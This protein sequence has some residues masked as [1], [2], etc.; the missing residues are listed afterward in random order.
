MLVAECQVK[1]VGIALTKIDDRINK[2]FGRRRHWAAIEHANAEHH[3]VL[4]KLLD[5]NGGES[6]CG[7][8]VLHG[9]AR[10]QGTLAIKTSDPLH[11]AQ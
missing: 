10:K 9:K 3:W 5:R 4:H 7:Y 2:D 6:S 8:L 11:E 1:L